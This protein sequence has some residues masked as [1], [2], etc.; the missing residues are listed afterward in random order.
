MTPDTTPRLM[1]GSEESAAGVD[2]NNN[3]N[4]GGPI[5]EGGASGAHSKPFDFDIEDEWGDG[6]E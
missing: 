5:G 6:W 4:I 3:I 2:N 1:A